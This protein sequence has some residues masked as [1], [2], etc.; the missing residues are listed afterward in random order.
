M[1]KAELKRQTLSGMFWKMSER[2]LAQLVSL[3]V[4]V[5]LARILMPDDYSIIS[6]VMIFFTIADVII[7]GGLNTALIQKKDADEKD[8]DTVFTTCFIASLIIYII[9]FFSAPFISRLYKKPLLIPAFR[10]MGFVVI[11]N[12]I[13]SIVTAFTS[14][15]LQFKLFFW[16]TFIGT[17]ISALIGIFMALHGFGP[18][19]LIAQHMSNYLID[20]IVLL[21]AT[22]I[23]LHFRFYKERYKELMSYG[24]KIL[25]ASIISKAYDE[26]LPLI[27]GLRFSTTDLA[28]YSKGRSFPNFI[29]NAIGSTFS[30]VLFPIMTKIQDD[31]KQLL[32]YTRQFIGVSTFCLFPAMLGFVAISDEFVRI[33]L[34]EKWIPASIYIKIFSVTFMLNTIQSGNIQVIKAMGRSDITLKMDIIKKVVFF[35]VIFVFVYFSADPVM[36]AWASVVNIVIATIINTFP[37]KS[38]IGYSYKLQIQDV[39]YNLV[40]SIVMA[41]IVYYTGKALPVNAWSLLGRIVIG[42]AVYITLNKLC[43]NPN[44]IKVL[45]LTKGMNKERTA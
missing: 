23:K 41:M 16:A 6:I 28:Y 29:N 2:I 43:K 1:N 27:T 24:W 31:R 12:A 44:Y 33:V 37:N 8:Y 7:S 42:A 25:A 40:T 15:K 20:T 3:V 13:K 32:A 5:V 36:L 34:T 19:A 14:A 38:L 39:S 35:I 45:N 30:S 17:V 21:F 18:W 9:I 4:S 22:K 10:V 11:I 26:S